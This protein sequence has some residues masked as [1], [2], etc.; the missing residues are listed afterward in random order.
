[1][2]QS[3]NAS[4]VFGRDFLE[5]RSRILELAASLDRL[6]LAEGSPLDDPRLDQLRQAIEVLLKPGTS[7]AESVQQI[8]SL[9]Y[10][11]S[12]PRPR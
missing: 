6:E 2:P 11:P 10:D 12:W 5:M 8:F 7:R 9:K 3:R 1:M 4:A